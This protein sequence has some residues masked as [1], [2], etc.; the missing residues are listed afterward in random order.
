MD[1]QHLSELHHVPMSGSLAYNRSRYG[2]GSRANEGR[3][4]DPFQGNGEV[5]DG[6]CKRL[7]AS[8][9]Y[10]RNFN[11][12]TLLPTTQWESSDGPRLRT[13]SY[14]I[15]SRGRVV[16]QAA[17]S[18]NGSASAGRFQ[19]WSHT[20]GIAALP[21]FVP[22]PAGQLTRLETSLSPHLQW[23]LLA[24][25]LE[26]VRAWYRLEAAIHGSTPDSLRV[27]A[28]RD[29]MAR[30]M[31]CRAGTAIDVRA[32]QLGRRAATYRQTTEDAELQLVDWLVEAARAYLDAPRF[33][34]APIGYSQGSGHP[35][36]S[37]WRESERL[38]SRD[39]KLPSERP[40]R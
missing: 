27:M 30:L 7:A 24:F 9:G 34:P 10:G 11:T 28:W 13:E 12:D 15:A 33:K 31:Y 18:I 8:Y 35:A 36:E 6:A 4:A 39:G 40:N 22:D 32:K 2:G 26:D 20:A 17:K 37:W 19:K 14:A 21:A 29:A 25:A 38:K 5:I 1:G 3:R 16:E 23:L